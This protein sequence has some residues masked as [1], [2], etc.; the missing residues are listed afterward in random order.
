MFLAII[1]DTYSEVKEEIAVQSNDFEISDYFKRGYNNVL[2]QLGARNVNFDI[3][4]ALRIEDGAS[5]N[6]T[7]DE[8][9][10][11]LKKCDFS[12]IEIEM[13]FARY[14]FDGRFI[15][16]PD[17]PRPNP[18]TV[19]AASGDDEEEDDPLRPKSGRQARSARSARSRST[20]ARPRTPAG[21]VGGEEFQLLG[22]RVDR[23]EHSVGSIV[24]KIDAVLIKLESM[25]KN[26]HRRKDTMN[27]ILGTIQEDDTLDEAAKRSKMEDLVRQE[28]DHW[29]ESR[30]GTSESR[31]HY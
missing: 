8:I 20:T 6:L 28:L 17:N 15:F 2:G 31:S 27:K 1:N 13:F 18:G 25:E 21:N 9:R 26:K 10:Q 22:R 12:D 7:Y 4:N 30:P 23:M 19:A 16:D 14:D 11:N 3:E 5:D 29:D 24:S